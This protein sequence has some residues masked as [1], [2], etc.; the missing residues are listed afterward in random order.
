MS[1][2]VMRKTVYGLLTVVVLA[3]AAYGV[4]HYT[5]PKPPVMF[6]SGNGR[7]ESTE[8]DITAKIPG[9]LTEV[10]AHEGDMVAQGQL[11][12]RIDVDELTAKLNQA[13]AQVMQTIENKKYAEAV[14]KQ[15]LSELSLAQ[16]NYERAKNLYVNKNIS[17]VQLQQAETNVDSIRA[18]IDASKASVVSAEAA[19]NAAVAQ[20]EAVEANLKDTE[21]VSPISGRV[22]YRLMEPGEVIPAGGKV[23]V[24]QDLTDV[25]MTIFL[26]TEY[27]GKID[28]GAESRIVLDALPGVA[29]PAKVSFISSEAQFTP[30]EIETQN[31]REKLVFRVKVRIDEALLEKYK[32]KVKTGLPGVAYVRLDKNA[33]WPQELGRLA[34]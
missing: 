28:I 14:V 18:A 10:L 5:R 4:Y 22:Q 23:L 32:E 20:K 1:K 33:E 24:V 17:L 13:K 16:K 34:K 8:A 26:P 21:L 15:K 31:E 27:A 30:K 2:S 19:I 29:I 12:A 3:A 6:A 9:R 11:M 7:I 25:Y